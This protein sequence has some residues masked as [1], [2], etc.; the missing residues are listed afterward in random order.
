MTELDRLLSRLSGTPVPG[1]LSGLE[2]DVWRRIEVERAAQ[3]LGWARAL[4]LPA[5]AFALL[6]GFATAIIS[7][8]ADPGSDNGMAIFSANTPLAPSTL[9]AKHS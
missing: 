5:T 8:P 9:L 6:L 3:G 4:P 1:N 2:A 7:T